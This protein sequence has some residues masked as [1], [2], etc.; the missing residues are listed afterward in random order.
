MSMA[1]HGGIAERSSAIVIS[2]PSKKGPAALGMTAGEYRQ[3]GST[4]TLATDCSSVSH[5]MRSARELRD[6]TFYLAAFICH[7]SSTFA[8]VSRHDLPVTTHA[9]PCA[10]AT[11]GLRASGA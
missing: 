5:R 2:M 6:L 7:S 4:T 8:V 1:G 3:R 9:L 11:F 10:S